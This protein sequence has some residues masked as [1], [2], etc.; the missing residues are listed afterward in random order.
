MRHRAKGAVALTRSTGGCP[1]RWDA[2]STAGSGTKKR[3]ALLVALGAG[4]LALS[5][6]STVDSGQAAVSDAFRISQATVD[7][8]ASEVSRGL[9][10]PPSQ[11]PAG[12][13]TAITQRLVQNALLQEKA[14]E[15]G[16]SLT[17][18]QLE[19]GM[20]ALTQAQGGHDQLIQAALQA[21]IP[22]SALADV[23][24][25]NLIV[26]QLSQGD[27]GATE[28]IAALS[29]ALHVEVSPRYGSWDDTTLSILP[30]SP[31]VKQPAATTQGTTQ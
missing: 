11:P 27:V 31:V 24:R 20:A 5:G 28:Q 15:L 25:T 1:W 7:A 19:Q 29:E 9:N 17:S 6:C 3:R 16:L 21:G 4:V 2:P 8:Q 14:D 22:E 30:G 10:E 12:L 23:V 26:E 13:A 18:A